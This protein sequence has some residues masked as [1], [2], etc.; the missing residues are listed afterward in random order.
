MQVLPARAV[1]LE[2]SGAIEFEGG[3]VRR[4][5]VGRASEKPGDILRD[6]VQHLARCAAPGHAL[7]AGQ[8]DREV[9]VPPPRKLPSL[10]RIDLGSKIALLSSLWFRQVR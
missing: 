3:L 6:N 10:H 5:E 1:G 2:I 8:E 7:G 4:R 9:S